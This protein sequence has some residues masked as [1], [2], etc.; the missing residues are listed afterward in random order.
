MSNHK[1]QKG[2]EAKTDWLSDWRS[3]VRVTL[4]LTLTG[5]WERG[6]EISG[7]IKGGEF[8]D[9]VTISFSRNT[10]LHTVS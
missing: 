2:L 5:S 9:W 10:L 1:S 4:I 3:V 8:L 6:N 7:S